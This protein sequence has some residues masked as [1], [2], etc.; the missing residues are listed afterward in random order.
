MDYIV[1]WKRFSSDARSIYREIADR[2]SVQWRCILE[3]PPKQKDLELLREL[4]SSCC[5]FRFISN[6][7]SA[8]LGIYDEKEIIVIEDPHSN[9]NDSAALWTNNESIVTIAQNYFEILWLKAT[10]EPVF[11]TES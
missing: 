2:G 1:S 4:N 9:L 8:V 3:Q 10:D 11:I 7:P 6:H 5:M